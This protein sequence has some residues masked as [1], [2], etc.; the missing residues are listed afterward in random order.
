MKSLRKGRSREFLQIRKWTPPGQ[1]VVGLNG[2]ANVKYKLNPSVLQKNI[3]IKIFWRS[4]KR[5]WITGSSNLSSKI[6]KKQEPGTVISRNTLYQIYC[7][8]QRFLRDDGHPALNIFESK[9]NR[10]SKA[11]KIVWMR[12]WNA[13]PVVVFAR[14]LKRLSHYPK[15]LDLCL[16]W[17]KEQPVRIKAQ[18]HKAKANWALW[19]WW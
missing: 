6:R 11:F 7:G 5:N 13:W 19:W 15:S 4:V 3:I 9:S 17:R 14:R 8:L 18:W 2:H 16:I 12:N 1:Y 10:C